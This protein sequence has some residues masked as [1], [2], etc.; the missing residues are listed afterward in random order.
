[1]NSKV[2]TVDFEDKSYIINKEG[3]SYQLSV[4][5]YG[6]I[7]AYNNTI[8]ISL[9][10]KGFEVL[11]GAEANNEL[12]VLLDRAKELVGDIEVNLDEPLDPEDEY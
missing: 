1:M 9:E 6:R 11:N 10:D 7:S 2:R 12:E 8:L 3:S 5:N 4:L